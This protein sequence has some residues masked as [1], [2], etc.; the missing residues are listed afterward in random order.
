MSYNSNA[1]FYFYDY[2]IFITFFYSDSFL[3][4]DYFFANSLLWSDKGIIPIFKNQ[5]YAFIL[6]A[7]LPSVFTRNLIAPFFKIFFFLYSY[8]ANNEYNNSNQ[9]NNAYA[10][11]H[12][13][14]D[15]I[16]IAHAKVFLV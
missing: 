5:I 14:D 2:L 6:M 10:R 8:S 3:K 16:D 4:F 12:A 1:I 13:N 11:I 7:N 9:A 15:A